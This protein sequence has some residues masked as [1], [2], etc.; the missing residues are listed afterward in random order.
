MSFQLQFQP[1]VNKEGLSRLQFVCYEF[2]SGK[3]GERKDPDNETSE[4]YKKDWEFHKLVF[5]VRGMVKGQEQKISMTFSSVYSPSNRLGVALSKLGY[6]PPIM[7]TTTDEDG[8]EVAGDE[9]EDGF[10]QIEAFDLGIEE[11]LKSI[12]G[13]VYV[14]QVKRSE[15]EK[16]KGLLVIVPETIKPFVKTAKV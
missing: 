15:D 9:D 11:F 1:A 12:E 6:E 3:A 5:A 2:K 4:V 8:F 10:G 7:Q 16:N 13:K 14:G